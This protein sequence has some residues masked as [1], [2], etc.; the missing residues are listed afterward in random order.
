VTQRQFRAI[1][2]LEEPYSEEEI[3]T[4]IQTME[5][6]M[7]EAFHVQSARHRY[8]ILKILEEQIGQKKE[9]V[10]LDKRRDEYIVILTETMLECKLSQSSGTSLKPG[11]LIQIT[12]QHADAQNDILSIFMG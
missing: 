1:L 8:W 9:A 3:R 6:P 12:I 2:G 4:I 7:R 11:D 5:N 10:V